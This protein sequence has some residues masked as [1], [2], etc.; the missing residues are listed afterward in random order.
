M[1]ICIQV[2][3]SERIYV[4]I[5]G[6]L[7]VSCVV[8]FAELAGLAGSMVCW[9]GSFCCVA[10]GWLVASWL[11]WLASWLAGWW[12]AVTCSGW[13]VGCLAAGLAGLIFAKAE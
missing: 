3:F 12:L 13:L 10:G 5:C 7:Q 4:S 9:P 8:N 2:L 6:I 1:A 11:V